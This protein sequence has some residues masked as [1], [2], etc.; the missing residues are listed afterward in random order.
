MKSEPLKCVVKHESVSPNS[1]LHL[2]QDIEARGPGRHSQQPSSG[3][4]K[5]DKKYEAVENSVFSRLPLR[6]APTDN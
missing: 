1:P 3:I 5:Q 2:L 6:G 4:P